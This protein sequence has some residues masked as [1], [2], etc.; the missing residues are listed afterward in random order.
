MDILSACMYVY[1]KCAAPRRGQK[2]LSDPMGLE[3]QMAV[4]HLVVSGN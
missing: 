1:L 3:L 4:S 2:M